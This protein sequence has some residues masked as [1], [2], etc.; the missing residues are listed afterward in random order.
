MVAGVNRPRGLSVVAMVLLLTSL[1]A[2][3]QQAT[4][5]SRI[6]WLGVSAGAS[7]TLAASFRDGLQQFGWVEG[8]DFTIE[9]R[10]ADGKVE[11]LPALAADLVRLNVDVI[12]ALG[13][14]APAAAKKVTTA[15]PIVMT[16]GGDPVATGLIV[17]LPRPGGNVTGLASMY[18]ELSGKRLELLKQAVPSLKRVAVLWNRDNASHGPALRAS[19]EAARALGIQ[20]H[21]VEFRTRQDF[22]P[23]LLAAKHARAGALLILDDPATFTHRE[24]LAQLAS[25]EGLP[26]IYPFREAG[27][28]GGLMAFGPNLVAMSR[29]AA[30]YV[31]KILRGARPAELPVEQPTVFDLVINVKAAKALGIVIS[32]SLLLRADHVIE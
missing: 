13:E 32:P 1:A 24:M 21:S 25:T 2:E 15:I 5:P 11:R 18:P 31:D 20:L 29:R 14:A 26:A 19:E 6:G 27:E 22:G 7:S 17:S 10:T 8:R 9:Y 12:V 28:A 30:G 4:K 3:A 16:F 23:A